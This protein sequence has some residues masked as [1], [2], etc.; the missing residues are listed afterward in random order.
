MPR[1]LTRREHALLARDD[2]RPAQCQFAAACTAS[3]GHARL[4]DDALERYGDHGPAISG[5]VRDHFP[6]DVR[7]MLRNMAR[8]VTRY[9]DAAWLARPARVRT[10]TMRDLS[11]AVAA[12]DGCGFYGPHA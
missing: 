8:N 3:R 1:A 5:C 11:R 6:A 9:S 12:R 4:A 10:A 7:D 2:L